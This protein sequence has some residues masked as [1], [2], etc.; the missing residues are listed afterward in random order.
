MS[1]SLL[2][3]GDKSIHFYKFSNLDAVE[4]CRMLSNLVDL[5]HEINNINYIYALNSAKEIV[6]FE[7]SQA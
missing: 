3:Y 6:L 4:P 2:M 1:H 7:V 5:V